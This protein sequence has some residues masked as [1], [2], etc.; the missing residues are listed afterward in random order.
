MYRPPSSASSAQILTAA[1]HALREAN[2]ANVTD[3][4]SEALSTVAEL[5]LARTRL[6]ESIQ[7]AAK[8]PQGHA[9][10]L[11]AEQLCECVREVEAELR[12]ETDRALTLMQRTK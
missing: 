4:A 7:A 10:E 6:L 1:L 2:V 9:R 5:L 3:E 11:L 8:S 12:V